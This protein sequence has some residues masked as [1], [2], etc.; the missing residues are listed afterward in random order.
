MQ[1]T[2]PNSLA[3]QKLKLIC[4]PLLYSAPDAPP[5]PPSLQG[6]VTLP[7]SIESQRQLFSDLA[8]TLSA[9]EAPEFT[10][11]LANY[12]YVPLSKYLHVNH[13]SELLLEGVFEA[14]KELV[15]RWIQ[16]PSGMDDAIFE[17]FFIL[18]VLKLGGPIDFAKSA[19]QK[20][21][22]ERELAEE[23]KLTIVQFLR[24]MMTGLQRNKLPEI[25]KAMRY[26]LINV[27]LD[28]VRFAQALEL[29]FASLELLSAFLTMDNSFL[30][31]ILAGLISTLASA[32]LNVP[33]L[34]VDTNKGMDS[35][36]MRSFNSDFSCRCLQVLGDI[37]RALP[38]FGGTDEA[39]RTKWTH[40][41]SL[42][43][44]HVV[45]SLRASER[46]KMREAL[47]AF[48]PSLLPPSS[49]FLA[50]FPPSSSELNTTKNMLITAILLLATD[51]FPE[52]ASRAT[53]Y[54]VDHLSLTSGMK[55]IV[56]DIISE[57][58]DRLPPSLYRRD[59]VAVQEAAK[60]IEAGCRLN[61]ISLQ[62][63]DEGEEGVRQIAKQEK[64]IWG[65]LRGL[66]NARMTQTKNVVEYRP[67]NQTDLNLL[68][69]E[70]CS[71][72][73][74]AEET[75]IESAVERMLFTIASSSTSA[76]IV[77]GLTAREIT[78]K[79]WA[80]SNFEFENAKQKVA[81]GEGKEEEALDE[82]RITSRALWVVG[83]L[84]SGVGQKEKK[85]LKKW[86][87]S[88]VDMINQRDGL[89]EDEELHVGTAAVVGDIGKQ[90]TAEELEETRVEWN[91]YQAAGVLHTQRPPSDASS[92]VL[93]GKRPTD[94]QIRK[95]LIHEGDRLICNGLSALVAISSALGDAFRPELMTTLYPVLRLQA[96]V[97]SSSLV[98]S[99][100][101]TSLDLIARNVGYSSTADLLRDNCDY[102]IEAVSAR[103]SP[104][105]GAAGM[106]G[107]DIDAP[108]VLVAMLRRVGTSSTV[109]LM[110]DVV[111]D[112]L[113]LLDDYHSYDAISA[114]LWLF[115]D[116]V[117]Q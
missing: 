39:E 48:A 97:S 16:C 2:E 7:R 72:P 8:R 106:R 67:Q 13:L 40:P 76:R 81:R 104:S 83:K 42:T 22:K 49:N 34:S 100:A 45:S 69:L 82:M 98:A 109:E 74:V 26:Q 5:L 117:V 77:H 90:I 9:I 65:I 92:L 73:L 38:P 6:T 88:I 55:Q 62:L 96:S 78:D 68:R 30:L 80:I 75:E 11:L 64:W 23:T 105:F 101:Q 115:L 43:L 10:L 116:T 20:K 15:V 44:E 79:F 21:G 93:S 86:I 51:D 52:V 37:L 54:C 110:R 24:G 17:Q 14:L 60:I 102:L 113:D 33:S 12:V 85:R 103:L 4:V 111:D 25:R 58:L 108:L 70:N 28:L 114:R 47:A 66:E 71:V 63:D 99:N 59:T 18:G 29:R 61:L 94:R 56:R 46:P 31:S 19:E 95:M 32:T 3:F 91:G 84:A 36:T 57:S 89:T 1:A 35:K 41:L 107:M 112:A 87:P 27:V 50:V 53:S